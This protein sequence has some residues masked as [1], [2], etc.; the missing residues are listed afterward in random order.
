MGAD[1]QEGEFVSAI[2]SWKQSSRD[3]K[4]N[5]NDTEK[6]LNSEDGSKLGS[7]IK[8]EDEKE[9]MGTDVS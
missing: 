7:F 3:D 5:I 4:E 2:N 8:I 9:N 1:S 6:R